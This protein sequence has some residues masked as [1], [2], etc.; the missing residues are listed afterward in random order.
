MSIF[1][2]NPNKPPQILPNTN[3]NK[4]HAQKQ[5]SNEFSTLLEQINSK[6][7]KHISENCENKKTYVNKFILNCYEILQDIDSKI[8]L[9]RLSLE[10]LL[11]EKINN[12]RL[13]NSN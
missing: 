1:L 6:V 11:E 13:L 9:E 7:I 8:E 4:K 5:K 2:P 10:L 3:I 12:E